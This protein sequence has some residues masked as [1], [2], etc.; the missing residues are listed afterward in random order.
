MHY[1]SCS[2][3][4]TRIYM[5]KKR[6]RNIRPTKKMIENPTKYVHEWEEHEEIMARLH[7]QK[8]INKSKDPLEEYCESYPWEKECKVFN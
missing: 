3:R 7:D 5:L 2:F 4:P 1:F 6:V 8:M